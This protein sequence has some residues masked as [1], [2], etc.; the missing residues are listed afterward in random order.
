MLNNKFLVNDD[1]GKHKKIYVRRDK[2]DFVKPSIDI[3]ELREKQR[4]EQIEEQL[5]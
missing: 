2:F 1:I 5:K 3:F 4:R